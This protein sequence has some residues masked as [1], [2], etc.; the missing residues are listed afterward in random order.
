MNLVH[1][2]L[3]KLLIC[4]V[5]LVACTGLSSAAEFFLRAQETTVTMPDGRQVPMWGFAQDSAFGV[6][7]GT[8][9]VPG[10]VLTVPE[11]DTTLTIHLWNKL[12]QG[13]PVSIVI[14]GQRA[15][16]TPVRHAALSIYAGRVR[17]FTMETEPDN[18][19]AVSYTWTN[20]R[21]GTFLYHS[22]THPAC[23]VQMGL[24]GCVRKDF[25]AGQAYDGVPYDRE[26]VLL[27]SEID[28]EFHDAVEKGDFGPGK[29][30]TSTT[31]YRPKYFLL[32]GAPYSPGTLPVAAGTAGERVLVRFLNAGIL[33]H[34]FLLQG[35]HMRTLAED[36]F[37]YRHPRERYCLNMPPLKTMD[38]L[39]TAPDGGTFALYDRTLRLTNDL[40]APGGLLTFLEFQD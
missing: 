38:A 19:T 29:L 27:A 20:F 31:N 28:P 1:A 39:I 8:V 26:V 4:T 21:P 3:T 35:L 17:S 30:V 6:D 12:P 33:T 23:Q 25:A 24:Y 16:M 15:A 14:P 22:G 11:G 36:G 37:A 18:E 32:N 9:T 34:A 40:E 5:T 7:D 10:P 13:N 2:R